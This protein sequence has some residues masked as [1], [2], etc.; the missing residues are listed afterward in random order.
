MIKKILA[1]ITGIAIAFTASS[2]TA[3]GDWNVH[4]N[5][6]YDV[7][8]DYRDSGEGLLCSGKQPFSL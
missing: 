3:V 4:N 6:S 2:A 1:A 7:I 5:F 8:Q